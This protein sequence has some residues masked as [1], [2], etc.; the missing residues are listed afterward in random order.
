MSSTA[1]TLT[2]ND[3]LLCVSSEVL[4]PYASHRLRKEAFGHES[5]N[6]PEFVGAGLHHLLLSNLQRLHV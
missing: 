4:L 3:E 6:V 5:V 1:T 2:V